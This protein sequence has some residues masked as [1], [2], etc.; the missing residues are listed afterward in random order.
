MSRPVHVELGPGAIWTGILVTHV[1]FC[2]LLSLETLFLPPSALGAGSLFLAAL[3]F[4]AIPAA[5]I[6][7]ALGLPLAAALRPV[8]NQWWHVGAFALL[9]GIMTMP[10]GVFEDPP[11]PLATIA[12]IPAAA[13]GRFSVWRLVRI[14]N[15]DGAA[16]APGV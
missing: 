9:G 3:M 5:V 8:R 12:M 14:R 6:G 11:M 10:F 16:P 1:S 13:Q 7:W 2:L 4:G 15:D